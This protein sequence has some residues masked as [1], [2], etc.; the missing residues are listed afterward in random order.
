MNC[1]EGLVLSISAAAI[2]VSKEMTKDQMNLLSLVAMQF[3]DT[4]ATL[5]AGS[6]DKR[7]LSSS[8]GEGTPR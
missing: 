2:A 8:A 5:A 7:G 3:A 4:L 1:S 6:E